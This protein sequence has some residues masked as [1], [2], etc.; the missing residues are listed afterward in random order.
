MCKGIRSGFELGRSSETR[1]D[2]R[3]IEAQ[4]RYLSTLNRQRAV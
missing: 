2:V 1:H 4:N 3:F